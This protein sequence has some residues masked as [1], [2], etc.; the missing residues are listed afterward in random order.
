MRRSDI[1]MRRAL[2][3]N[4]LG[5]TAGSVP[6]R[7]VENDVSESQVVLVKNPYEDFDASM[8]ALDACSRIP[9]NRA[10]RRAAERRRRARS[11]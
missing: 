4:A 9:A 7:V 5:A 3:A 1:A 6:P 2:L 11:R 10:E 8:A